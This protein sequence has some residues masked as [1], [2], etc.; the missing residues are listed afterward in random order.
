MSFGRLHSVQGTRRA[1]AG[2]SLIELMIAIT[3][4][5]VAV[6]AAMA[7]YLANRKS[8]ALVEGV[9]RV[10]ENARFAVDLLSR[11]I[12]EAGGLVCGGTLTTVNIVSGINAWTVW[13]QGL[14]GNVLGAD[15]WQLPAPSDP[16][17]A[18]ISG[19]HSLLVW[20]ASSSGAPVQIVSHDPAAATFTTAGAPGYAVGQVITACDSAQ[21]ITFEVASISGNIVGYSNGA[22]VTVP[23]AAG[24]F[25]NPLSAKVWFVG[26]ST[27]TATPS[28]LRRLTLNKEG[29]YA[30][31]NDEMVSGVTN[32][33][34]QYMVGDSSGAPAATTYADAANVADWTR[35][36]AARVTLSLATQD[37][38]G[39]TGSAN[40]VVTHDVPFTVGIK[41]RLP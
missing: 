38:V 36:I 26:Q 31:N 1:Q 30:Y 8:F 17:K 24:G 13:S 27:D 41:R 28:S 33:Q 7:I 35:V 23:L 9:A 15:V 2:V 5:L 6:G 34:I 29:N 16:N 12:R 37:S 4:G 22:A 11:D 14:V 39:N 32:M 10:Q 25:L 3:L 40:T 19:T 18:Q 20:S 21:A